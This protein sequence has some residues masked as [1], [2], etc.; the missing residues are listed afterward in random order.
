MSCF[1]SQ[2][3]ADDTPERDFRALH[4]V[5]AELG[6]GVHAKIKFRQIPIQVLLV[7]V[8]VDADQAAFEDRKETFKGV[9]VNVAA[10]KFVLGVIHRFVL[11]FVWASQRN[12]S[13]SHQ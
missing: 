5:N 8:L 4:I 1:I 6:A 7:H 2:S 12:R 13:W 11:R 9:G 3:L 10:H